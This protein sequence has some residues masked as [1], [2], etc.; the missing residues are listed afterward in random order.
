MS[1]FSFP[2]QVSILSQICKPVSALRSFYCLACNA[3]WFP[4]PPPPALRSVT[5][6]TRSALSVTLCRP[7]EFSE[8]SNYSSS[9]FLMG[10]RG[11]QVSWQFPR[12]FHREEDSVYVCVSACVNAHA[13]VSSTPV[14]ALLCPLW[15]FE[16]QLQLSVDGP[17]W[18]HLVPVSPLVLSVGMILL[19]H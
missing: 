3:L 7:W 16:F 17:M 1:S 6:G 9:E 12:P 2:G 18:V 13:C 15:T 4:V 14:W 11:P 19:K 8:L 10:Q 5:L